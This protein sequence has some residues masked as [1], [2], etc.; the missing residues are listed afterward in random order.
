MTLL[1]PF[2]E[3]VNDYD[4]ELLDIIEDFN[5]FCDNTGLLPKRQIQDF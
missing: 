4:L 2:K 5:L 1:K 3:Q